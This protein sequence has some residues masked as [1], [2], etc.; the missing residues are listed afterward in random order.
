YIATLPN[1]GYS[2]IEPV[3]RRLAAVPGAPAAA[4]DRGG[5]GSPSAWPGRIIGRDRSIQ[6]VAQQIQQR[7]LVTVVGTG[8]VGKTTLVLSVTAQMRGEGEKPA[9]Q[10]IV[11]VDLASLA[12]GHAVPSAFASALGAVL[13]GDDGI[14]NIAHYLR[15]EACLLVIDNCEHVVDPVV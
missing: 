2:F 13:A 15:E 7:R 3:H 1:R 12:D 6:V 10:K 5:L 9:W 8:G 11:F 4:T 14:S